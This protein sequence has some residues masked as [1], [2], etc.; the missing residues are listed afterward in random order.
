GFGLIIRGRDF[1]SL[2]LLCTRSRRYSHRTQATK[3]K[4]PTVK[5]TITLAES[6]RWVEPQLSARRTRVPAM[7]KMMA[8]IQSIRV[9]FCHRD[10]VILSDNGKDSS[11]S[12]PFTYPRSRK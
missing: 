12:P 8:P 2:F 7:T 3:S 11:S 9:A 4:P 5:L 1:V 6:H 10:S